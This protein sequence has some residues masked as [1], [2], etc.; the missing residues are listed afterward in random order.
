MRSLAIVGL[1]QAPLAAGLLL[2]PPARWGALG[3]WAITQWL[4]L[5]GLLRPKSRWLCPA[6]ERGAAQP[7]VALT[8]DDGPH[9]QDTPAILDRLAARQV[10]ATFFF[11]GERARAHPEL[12][13]RAAREGHQTEAHSDTHPWWFSLAGP[14]RVR[15]EVRESAAAIGRIAGRPPAWFRSP[16]GHKNLFLRDELER[17]GLRLAGWSVRPF[18]TLGRPARAIAATVLRGAAPGG[19]IVLHEGVSRPPGTES[20]VIEALD[21]ILEGLAARGL[22]PVRLEDLA[23]SPRRETAPAAA[24]AAGSR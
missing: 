12:V 13:K 18:D 6:F 1:S 7:R 14:A 21:R 23:G 5:S 4:V 16:M 10:A 2:A 8:F 19:V 17:A 15:R 24:R 3:L 9:P 11:V 22:T 20:P